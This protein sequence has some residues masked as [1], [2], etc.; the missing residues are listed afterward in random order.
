[1]NEGNALQVSFSHVQFFVNQLEELSSYQQLQDTLNDLHQHHTSGSCDN[2]QSEKQ[3][4]E[5]LSGVPSPPGF[6]SHGRD[7]VKQ[8]LVGLGFRITRAGPQRLLVTSKDP[9][10]VQFIISARNTEPNSSSSMFTEGESSHEGWPS[11]YSA[12]SLSHVLF[13]T[14]QKNPIAFFMLMM[15][16]WVSVF[17]GLQ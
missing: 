1:M 4:W 13:R 2:S 10:G 3:A 5:Q 17:L 15:D 14:S 16:I 11:L 9:R 8:F 7:V 6:V 12:A